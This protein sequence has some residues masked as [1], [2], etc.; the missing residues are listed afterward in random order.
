MFIFS[1][2]GLV[3]ILN[4]IFSYWVGNIGGVKLNLAILIVMIIMYIISWGIKR[5]KKY[6]LAKRK[7]DNKF[8]SWRRWRSSP[9]LSFV[10]KKV[11]KKATTASKAKL[12][13]LINSFFSALQ[14]SLKCAPSTFLHTQTVSGW[15]RKEKIKCSASAYV[16]R[17]PTLLLNL[18]F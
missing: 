1:F 4:T 2:I 12:P 18:F 6:K 16:V 8:Y 15:F 11:T 3:L 9:L 7:M 14:N 17:C 5:Y 10:E 13:S